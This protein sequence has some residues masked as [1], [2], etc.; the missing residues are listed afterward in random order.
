MPDLA[1]FRP[2]PFARYFMRGVLREIADNCGVEATERLVFLK[3]GER[4]YVSRTPQTWLAAAL[5]EDGA[6]WLADVYGDTEI[7]L[8]QGPRSHQAMLTWCA[9]ELAAQGKSKAE[10]CRET[11]LSTRHCYEVLK[12]AERMQPRG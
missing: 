2:N 3:K 1:D 7:T 12:R 6:R 9:W 5:G 4:F 10:I 11:G 8:P